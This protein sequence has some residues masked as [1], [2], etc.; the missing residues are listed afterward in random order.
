MA[1]KVSIDLHSVWFEASPGTLF[2]RKIEKW[3]IDELEETV[4]GKA[5]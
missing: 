5:R 1:G 2:C 3:L 4:D